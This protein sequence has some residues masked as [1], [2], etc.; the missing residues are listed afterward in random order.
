LLVGYRVSAGDEI[1][2]QLFD[3]NQKKLNAIPEADQ[4]R[5]V[6]TLEDLKGSGK[7]VTID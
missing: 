4:Q 2:S 5:L 1:A 6:K 7:M 3:W